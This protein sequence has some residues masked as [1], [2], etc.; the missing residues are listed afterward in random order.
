MTCTDSRYACRLCRPR[1]CTGIEIIAQTGPHRE[2]KGEVLPLGILHPC[3]PCV[4]KTCPDTPLHVR[5]NPPV[6]LDKIIPR[7]GHERGV[8]GF[9][10]LG[11]NGVIAAE[12]YIGIP[13]QE[14]GPADVVKVPP[15]RERERNQ[16]IIGKLR[17]PSPV[18]PL[19][20]VKD[21]FGVVGKISH[22][23]TDLQLVLEIDLP[24]EVIGTYG[25][26]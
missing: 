8:I 26:C 14:P 25:R 18:L 24:V 4:R 16:C 17:R 23:K 11:Y 20:E 5:S 15:E 21:K 19:H 10:T 6:G 3:P 9:G 12:G 1:R 7:P 2:G 13:T 22:V